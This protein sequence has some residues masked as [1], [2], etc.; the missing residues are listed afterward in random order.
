MRPT[1]INGLDVFSSMYLFSNKYVTI[2]KRVEA[3]EYSYYETSESCYMW[4]DSMFDEI[5][6]EEE[7][8]I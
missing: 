5:E 6:W 3:C 4:V 2:S 8:D 1:K 7:Y